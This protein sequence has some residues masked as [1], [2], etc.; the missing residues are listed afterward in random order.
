MVRKS[1]KNFV[2]DTTDIPINEPVS[3]TS[4]SGTRKHVTC[5]C[6]LCKGRKVDPRTRALHTKERELIRNVEASDMNTGEGSRPTHIPTDVSDDDFME[7]DEI[8]DNNH[9]DNSGNEQ[10]FNFLV[11]KSKVKGKRKS[12]GSRRNPLVVIEQQLLL[13]SD[14]DQDDEISINDEDDELE[15][16]VNFDAP[17]S[18]YEDK[19]TSIQVTNI[20]QR[21]IWIVYWILKYQERHRLSDTA[22]NSLIKFIRYI[23]ILSDENTYST[24]PKSLYMARKLFGIDDQIIK[25]ATCKKCCKLYAIKDLPTD[26]PFHCTFQNFPKHPMA[27]LRTSCNAIV[28]KQVYVNHILT[29]QPSLI[30][31]IASI[32]QQLQRL[33]NRKGF[34]ESCRKWADRPN[35]S[36]MLADIYDGR[37][38]KTFRD[39]NQDLPFFRKEVSD[40]HLGIMLNMD[41]FQP[42]DNSQYSVGAIYGVICNLPRSER[43]KTSN[44]ITLAVIPGPNEPKLHQL[45]H[46]LAPIIDQLIELWNGIELS[47]TCENPNGKLIRAAVICCACDIPAARKLCGYI[48]ARIACHRCKKRANIE[49]RNNINFGGFDDIDDWFVPRDVEEIRKNASL[50][51][52]CDTDDARKRHVSE[53]FVRWSEIYRLPYFDPVQF[54]VVDPMHCLFLGIAK[55]IVTRLWIEEGR[56]T[57]D[58][59]EI[60]QER[61]NKIKVPTDIGRI[62]NKITMGEGFSGFTADQWKTFMLVYATTVTWDLLSKDDK[63]ILSY[64]VR[65]CNILVCRIISKSGLE[66]AHQCLLSMVELVEKSY[67][68]EKITPNMHLCLHICE[69]AFDYGPLYSFWCYSFERMNGL[70]GNMISILARYLYNINI[71]LY[72]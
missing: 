49:G 14:V 19:D 35:D 60:M 5:D 22:T 29:Y 10:E 30:Y 61:A 71:F 1:K 32:K 52:E 53:T 20:D 42:F 7:I 4:K 58:H 23:L 13:D 33:Y 69:C 11:K 65:A 17:E 55:W 6:N 25:Y 34:E 39:S 59:L 68:P 41:W 37:I 43:F 54:L 66:E 8:S 36:Q 16:T 15:Q 26:R 64:F 24:F 9:S 56:L 50:W 2:K 31:P 38:W 12:S 48:S 18:G 44:I 70:L 47:V 51:K 63:E 28:T 57:S 72:L 45:N 21:F 46:Y 67:G 3:K 27:N 62:P 40:C